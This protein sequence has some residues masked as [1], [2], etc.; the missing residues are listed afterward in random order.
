[1]QLR[2]RTFVQEPAAELARF[3]AHAVLLEMKLGLWLVPTALVA[4]VGHA[5]G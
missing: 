3:T 1:V 2:Q 4:M 5:A